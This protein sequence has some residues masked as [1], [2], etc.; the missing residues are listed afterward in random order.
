[1]QA[2]TIELLTGEAVFCA[3]FTAIAVFPV[4]IV[5]VIAG[6]VGRCCAILSRDSPLGTQIDDGA[7][8]RSQ[9]ASRKPFYLLSVIRV[10]YEVKV[11]LC[12]NLHRY[13]L[14]VTIKSAIGPHPVYRCEKND[15]AP[16]IPFS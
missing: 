1:M 5:A 4:G 3:D 12:E 7:I 13:K 8:L 14:L 2:H 6:G 15:Q 11:E 9:I 10:N 16:S